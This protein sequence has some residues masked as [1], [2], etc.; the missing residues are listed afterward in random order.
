MKREF[1]LMI[2]GF[3]E[4][5]IET[6]ITRFK[7]KIEKE[8]G[9]LTKLKDY[10]NFS[11]NYIVSLTNKDLDP[12][13]KKIIRTRKFNERM[14]K[15]VG[16]VYLPDT[17]EKFLSLHRDKQTLIEIG[18]GKDAI[19]GIIFIKKREYYLKGPLLEDLKSISIH[20]VSLDTIL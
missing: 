8:K 16:G 5:Y 4:Q 10:E 19:K 13:S 15:C 3:N 9:M 12:P 6:F 7:S 1:Y 18:E 20:E 11:G 14:E 17:F 2:E